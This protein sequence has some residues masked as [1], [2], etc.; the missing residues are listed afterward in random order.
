MTENQIVKVIVQAAYEIH[1]TLGPDT[2]VGNTHSLS[3]E[4][5]VPISVT[6]KNIKLE[7]GFLSDLILEVKVLVELKLKDELAP[8][9]LKQAMTYLRLTNLKPGLLINFN[10]SLSKNRAQKSR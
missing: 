1:I 6:R 3:V 4:R 7:L 10:E 5:Q 9:H 8:M 2:W